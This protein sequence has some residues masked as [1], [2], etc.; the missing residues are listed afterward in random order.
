M[1]NGR[2]ENEWWLEKFK[3]IPLNEYKHIGGGGY[4]QVY[5]IKMKTESS[6]LAVKIV[7]GVGTLSNYEAQVREKEYAW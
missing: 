2:T 4:G 6:E 5:K 3:L 1:L 7:Q